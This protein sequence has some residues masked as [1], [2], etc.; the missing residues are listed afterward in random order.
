MDEWQLRNVWK[1]RQPYNRVAP[2]S[3]PLDYLL[4][5]QLA[6]RVK[7]LGQLAV[8][9]DECIPEFI[10]EHASLVSFNHGTLTAAVDSA[11][12]RYQLQQLLAN[13]LLEALRERFRSGAL[14]RVRV[15]PGRYDYLEFPD[16][17]TQ[18]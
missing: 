8:V 10:R 1:N 4:Q 6:K 11:P 18:A 9:W 16:A 13:G 17:R 7:Q 14:N 15:V 5:H 12:H 2:L 3:E